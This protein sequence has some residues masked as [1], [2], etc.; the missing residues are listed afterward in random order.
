VGRCLVRGLYS[1][2]RDGI[3]G[4]SLGKLLVGLVVVNVPTGRLCSWKE[5]SAAQRL[6]ADSRRNVV[7][8]FLESITLIRDPQGSGSA[9]AW[10]RPRSSKGSGAKDLA[11]S[12]QSGG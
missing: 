1:L 12:F 8:I 7:A 4:Q 3:G 9:I 6:R 10:R 5:F 11:T 2:L